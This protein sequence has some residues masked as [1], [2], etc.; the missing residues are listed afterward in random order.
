M[1]NGKWVQGWQH[2]SHML[3]KHQKTKCTT[4]N[5]KLLWQW[6]LMLAHP[7]ISFPSRQT[8]GLHIFAPLSSGKAMWLANAGCNS[9][10]PITSELK[11]LLVGLSHSAILIC[12]LMV[13]LRES[14]ISVCLDHWVTTWKATDLE[15]NQTCSGCC[16]SVGNQLRLCR[17]LKFWPCLFPKHSQTQ[18]AY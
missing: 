13:K 6:I 17:P 15:V 7:W 14:D 4:I 2:L 9:R 18:S 11:H 10:D 5:I 8:W 1:K 3:C 16:I 12:T